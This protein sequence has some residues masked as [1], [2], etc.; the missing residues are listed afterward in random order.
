MYTNLHQ[1]FFKVQ[2]PELM[3]GQAE[4]RLYGATP[5]GVDLEFNLE[6]E[7]IRAN[8]GRKSVVFKSI[9]LHNPVYGSYRIIL[10]VIYTDKNAEVVSV[11]EA[12]RLIEEL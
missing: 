1:V 9:E 5:K 8:R 10:H 2:N 3:I 7:T 4:S 11:E 12:I 6:N